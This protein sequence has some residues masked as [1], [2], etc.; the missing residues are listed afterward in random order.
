LVARFERGAPLNE[1]NTATFYGHD[2]EGYTDYA[3]LE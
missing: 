2:A 3:T 1:W